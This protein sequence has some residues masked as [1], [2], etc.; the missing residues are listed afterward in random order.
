MAHKPRVPYSGAI[1]HVMNGAT[2]VRRNETD[3]GKAKVAA[4]LRA[5]TGMTLDWIAERLQIGCR[6][7]QLPQRAAHLPI[8]GTPFLVAARK[9]KEHLILPTLM[10]T[11]RSSRIS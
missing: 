10:T 1:Y 11:P 6:H 8:A 9:L 4:R 2:G 5:K 7:I 3:A